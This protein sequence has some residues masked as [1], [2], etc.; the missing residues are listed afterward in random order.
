MG[1]Q[2]SSSGG[3]I[4]VAKDNGTVAVYSLHHDIYKD[5]KELIAK[6]TL[7]ETALNNFFQNMEHE[8]VPYEKLDSKL[9]EIVDKY[10][11]LKASL[12]S[13]QESFKK[14]C[15][16]MESTGHIINNFFNTIEHKRC[17]DEELDRNL[18]EIAN[19]YNRLK[20]LSKIH[21]ADD[22]KV[23]Q[24]KAQVKHLIENGDYQKARDLLRQAEFLD[25]KQHLD[26]I[27]EAKHLLSAVSTKIERANLE[28]N[29]LRYAES[30][31]LFE[32]AAKLLPEDKKKEQAEYL[33]NAG[34]DFERVNLDADSLRLLKES[35]MIQQEIGDLIGEAATCWSIGIIYKKQGN[36][37]K[38]EQHMNHTVQLEK[39]LSL[40]EKVEHS[41][42]LHRV[43]WHIFLD[44]MS[45]SS[46]IR[47]HANSDKIYKE[48]RLKKMT[49]LDLFMIRYADVF[50]QAADLIELLPEDLRKKTG[51]L[52][53][54]C[55]F[56]FITHQQI[57]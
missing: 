12:E 46:L 29:Q 32:Q 47:I 9:R 22:A 28:R 16:D 15:G 1:D 50:K 43:S 4:F 18:Q 53:E 26:E 36:L 57:F 8:T 37:K 33:Y 52:S 34:I 27:N 48:K 24:I 3:S 38:A 5:I 40:P 56:K 7:A 54:Q 51:N 23:I 30:A 11:E 19:E 10:K 55:R 25:L 31:R 41:K 44:E 6:L 2:V 39:K 45:F 42:E 14:H 35:L 17:A 21:Q 20:H 49:Y 13:I